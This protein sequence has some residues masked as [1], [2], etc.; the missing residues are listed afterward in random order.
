V[1][2]VLFCIYFFF[3]SLQFVI[4]AINLYK[5]IINRE[6]AIIKL[7]IDIRDNTKKYSESD[8]PDRM[9]KNIQDSN[10]ENDLSD[11]ITSDIADSNTM[12]KISEEE[13][14]QGLGINEVENP[15]N[16]E[17]ELVKMGLR[18][19]SSPKQMNEQSPKCNVVELQRLSDKYENSKD[20]I[21]NEVKKLLQT[22]EEL[23]ILEGQSRLTY[24]ELINL[25]SDSNELTERGLSVYQLLIDR[26]NNSIH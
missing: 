2:F 9:I 12:N 23:R 8:L 25:G 26:I 24:S 13:I 19:D 22:K 5:K 7:L 10:T 3:K 21:I 11:S 14:I 20:T 17:A 16:A 18:F 4:S 6:D 1:G 15:G